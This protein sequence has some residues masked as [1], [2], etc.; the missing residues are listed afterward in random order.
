MKRFILALLCIFAGLHIGVAQTAGKPDKAY[1]KIIKDYF[2]G[3]ANKDW[4]QVSA[5]LA[6]GF[7]FTSAAPDDHISVAKFK[8]KCWVQA[9]HIQRFEFPKITGNEREAFAI[10][11]VIT[12]ENKVI[13]NVEYFNF[14][15]GKIKSI[16]VFFGGNG[17]GFPTN[18]KQP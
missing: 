2:A 3:W 5:Q 1:E 17:Q 15:N 14:A 10:V 9:Q 11:H 4:N 12:K 7:T 18:D 13:R 8:E 16:E 6:D